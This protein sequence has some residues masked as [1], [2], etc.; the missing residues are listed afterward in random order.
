[1]VVVPLTIYVDCSLVFSGVF[2]S[3]FSVVCLPER[4]VNPND[5]NHFILVSSNPHVV[6]GV[7]S[8]V[9]ACNIVLSRHKCHCVISTYPFSHNEARGGFPANKETA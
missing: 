3:L 2:L 6:A 8:C 4:G 9:Y 1:M 7:H 5:N